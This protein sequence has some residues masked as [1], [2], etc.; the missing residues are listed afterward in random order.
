VVLQP[1]AALLIHTGLLMPGATFFL[2][3]FAPLG[4]SDPLPGVSFLH[5]SLPMLCAVQ[6]YRTEK[7]IYLPMANFA[8]VC[9]C[10]VLPVRIKR[11]LL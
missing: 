11:C 10:F 3:Y 9:A 6:P 7:D 1:A 4:D 8:T 2:K 5:P